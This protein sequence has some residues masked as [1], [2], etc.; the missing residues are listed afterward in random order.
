MHTV[1]WLAR[2]PLCEGPKAQVTV[3]SEKPWTSA[4]GT[5]LEA[6]RVLRATLALSASCMPQGK[7]LLWEQKGQTTMEKP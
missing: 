2:L 6:G 3:C 4:E 7:Q 1:L 5:Y